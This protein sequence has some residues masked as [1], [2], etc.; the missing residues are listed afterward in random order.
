MA[1]STVASKLRSRRIRCLLARMGR[2]RNSFNL[3]RMPNRSKRECLPWVDVCLCLW[4]PASVDP[5][6]RNGVQ[7]DAF[8][9]PHIDRP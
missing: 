8:E 3:Q 6:H 9:A 4:Q 7:V 5:L 2:V 1:T